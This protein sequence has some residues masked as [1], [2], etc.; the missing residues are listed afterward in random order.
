M[1]RLLMLVLTPH[2][3]T[4]THHPD[5]I[6]DPTARPAAEAFYVHLKLCRDTLVD[7]AK[8]FA[9]DRFGPEILQWRQAVTIADYARAG[10]QNTLLY[11]T[12]TGAVLLLLGIVGYL[13]Q[14]PFVSESIHPYPWSFI[15]IM[16]VAILCPGRTFLFRSAHGDKAELPLDIRSGHQSIPGHLDLK[17]TISTIPSACPTKEADPGLLHCPLADRTSPGRSDRGDA[18]HDRPS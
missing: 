2:H 17:A 6:S 11:Y 3:R 9:Y 1:K 18:G 5:K 16:I 4:V 12:G 13:K 10:V 7:P 14:A 8:R 15:L